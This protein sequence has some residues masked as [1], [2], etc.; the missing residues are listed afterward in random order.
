M[1]FRHIG[2]H[3]IR[4]RF[5]KAAGP[6][7]ARKGLRARKVSGDFEKRAT[8]NDN[9]FYLRSVVL[10]SRAWINVAL[11]QEDPQHWTSKPNERK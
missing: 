9:F 5:P 2:G 7:R 11:R 3:E 6:F 8:E 10:V 4:A 1:A